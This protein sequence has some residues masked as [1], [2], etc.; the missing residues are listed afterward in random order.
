[1]QPQMKKRFLAPRSTDQ[2]GASTS[3]GGTSPSSIDSRL[4]AFSFTPARE[5]TLTAE[6][7]SEI[8]Q[9]LGIVDVT[10]HI[11]HVGRRAI[12]LKEALLAAALL[13][14]IKK[15]EMRAKKFPTDPF[16]V[17]VGAGIDK[18]FKD[19]LDQEWPTHPPFDAYPQKAIYGWMGLEESVEATGL[20]DPWAH[21]GKWGQRVA[22]SIE[23][24]QPVTNV[25]G[26]M[27][28]WYVEESATAAIEQALIGATFR[29][30]PGPAALA[31]QLQSD[32]SPGECNL[33]ELADEIA[34][35]DA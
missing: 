28:V 1:M 15:Y 31:A 29:T 25:A 10:G 2:S 24:A 21:C 14:N 35:E 33:D 27:G 23:F 11:T 3:A 30:F 20:K 19:M 12:T 9:P 34:D 7:L 17:H 26:S 4:P 18:A 8:L 16:L 22:W 6:L 32:A 13:R 5:L